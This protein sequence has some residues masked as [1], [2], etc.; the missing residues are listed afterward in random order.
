[1]N[2][3]CGDFS[4]QIEFASGNID[5]CSTGHGNHGDYMFGWKGDSLQRALDARCDN[6]RCKEL[7]RQSDED[8]MKCRIAQTAVEDVGD[9]SC[10]LFVRDG[11]AIVD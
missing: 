4:R 8:A 3:H 9:D 11:T 1:M 6:D 10:K 2:P 5:D 7:L